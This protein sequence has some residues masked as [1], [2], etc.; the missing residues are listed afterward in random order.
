MLISVGLLSVPA[1]G[2]AWMLISPPGAH[3][4][5]A[6][7]PCGDVQSKS[8]TADAVVATTLLFGT[9][10][11]AGGVSMVVWGSQAESTPTTF[12]L[13]LEPTGGALRIDF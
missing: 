9:L 7:D 12:S 3:A 11:I 13:E 2:L 5:P 6:V 10:S 8:D 1:A 4:C